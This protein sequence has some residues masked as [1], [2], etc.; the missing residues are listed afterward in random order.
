[1]K[2]KINNENPKIILHFQRSSRQNNH[3]Y[4]SETRFHIHVNMQFVN[5]LNETHSVKSMY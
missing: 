3:V 1:M 5:L 2:K 4:L